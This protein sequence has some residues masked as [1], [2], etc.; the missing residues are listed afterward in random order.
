MA[1]RALFFDLDDTLC[2]YSGSVDSAASAI[3]GRAVDRYPQ[4][5]SDR[6]RQNFDRLLDDH[7]V[8]S[9]G[10]H[11]PFL[12]RFDRIRQTL[13]LDQVEDDALAKE[14]VGEYTLMR[15]DG[16]KLFPDALSTLEALKGRLPMVLVTNGS[17]DVQKRAVERL[18]I[19]KYF[20]RILISEEVGAAKPNPLIFQ[21]AIEVVRRRP[22]EVLHVGDGVRSDIAG[23]KAAE[24]PVAWLN[25]GEH[26]L[27]P[28]DPV[29]NY[30]ISSLTELL[31]LVDRL[32]GEL[33]RQR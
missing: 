12:S 7:V 28:N 9:V 21:R 20:E 22:D 31:P 29:P 32:V 5:S 14:L 26:P 3:F 30:T 33:V 1:L 27:L 2:D 24:I 8:S 19:G 18:G 13:L 16:L 11:A 15:S 17:T 23:A 10:P 25:R 4:L 6:L